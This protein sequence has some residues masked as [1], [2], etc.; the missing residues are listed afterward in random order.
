MTDPPAP[1]SD[2]ETPPRMPR[3]VKVPAM[4]LGILILVFVILQ[5]T[6]VG[7]D[8]G[9]GR[10]LPGGDS[11]PAGFSTEQVSVMAVRA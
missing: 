3:W 8:H 10:H 11:S 1:D 6:G 7:G 9:P 5:L 2:H 4:V